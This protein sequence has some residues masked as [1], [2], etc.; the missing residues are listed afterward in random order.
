MSGRTSKQNNQNYELLDS[1]CVMNIHNFAL[2]PTKKNKKT[3]K[4]HSTKYATDGK[5]IKM[6]G[7]S[8]NST[9]TNLSSK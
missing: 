9:T 7:T 2:L 3:K 6:S 1:A 4:K 5:N 8:E